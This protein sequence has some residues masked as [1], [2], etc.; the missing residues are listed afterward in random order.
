M[1]IQPKGSKWYVALRL[2]EPLDKKGVPDL[3]TYLQQY[4]DEMGWRMTKFQVRRTYVEFELSEASR[5]S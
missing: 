1:R 5:R 4:A 3:R 2:A